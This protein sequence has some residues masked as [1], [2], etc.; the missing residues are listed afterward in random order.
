MNLCLI[1]SA[2]RHRVW[3]GGNIAPPFLTSSLDEGEWSASH[4]GSFT[5][6]KEP[7]VPVVYEAGWAPESVWTLWSGEISLAE[8]RTPAFQPVAHRFTDWAIPAHM[9]NSIVQ[10]FSGRRIYR[11][12]LLCIRKRS[13]CNKLY[14]V[15]DKFRF[16]QFGCVFP[17][18]VLVGY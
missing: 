5:R 6:G 14:Y 16:L 7:P 2:S 13:N 9:E 12:I 18:K 4:T 10:E 15:G 17:Q 3:W 1:N 8:N 11:W